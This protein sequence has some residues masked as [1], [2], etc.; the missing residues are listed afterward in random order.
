MK[1]ASNA[2]VSI[3]CH[4]LPYGAENP[5]SAAATHQIYWLREGVKLLDNYA[6]VLEKD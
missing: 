5:I 2:G 1:A 4:Y 3:R 6:A